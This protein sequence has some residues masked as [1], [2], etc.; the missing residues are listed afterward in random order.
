M[1]KV[2]I[3]G[4]ICL[5]HE[6]LIERSWQGQ[7]DIDDTVKEF[8]QGIDFSIATLECPL[9]GNEGTRR[10]KLALHASPRTIQF[11]K[12]LK[13]RAVTLANNHIADY[14]NKCGL[15]TVKLLEEEG[16][17]WF[18][19]GYAGREGNPAIFEGGGISFACLGYSDFPCDAVFS[20]PETFGSARYSRASAEPLI[21]DLKRKVDHVLVFMHWGMED[22]NYPVPENIRT[23]H[24]IIDL[25]ADAII[26]SHAHVYQGCEIYKDK[27][28][29]YNLGNLIFGDIVAVRASENAIFTR[30]QSLRNRIGLVP[31]FS[32]D[33]SGIGL[34]EVRFV[35]FG[36]DNAIVMLAGLKA[37]LN[38][39]YYDWISAQLKVRVSNPDDY[40]G[41][42][43][44]NIK[45]FVFFNLVERAIMR[46]TLF[47]PGMHH[48]KIF[49]RVSQQGVKRLETGRWK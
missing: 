15:A 34:D 21:V 43:N 3:M 40:E 22:V 8:V 16:I 47:R 46:G 10:N 38:S 9:F 29:L 6:A 37:A 24:E 49:Q 33:E 30:I 5:Q 27:Y 28:V 39:F 7:T 44:R 17:K 26:G 32:I 14:G 19:A 31:V 20:S 18:G 2:A 13:V 35:H 4:D 25:G 45:K 41:W 42:W 48:L 12:S 1:I 23:A 36:K 11:L